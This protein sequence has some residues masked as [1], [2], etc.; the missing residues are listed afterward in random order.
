MLLKVALIG[1]GAI[2]TVLAQAIDEGRA[3]KAELRANSS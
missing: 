1:C 3:G 2:G